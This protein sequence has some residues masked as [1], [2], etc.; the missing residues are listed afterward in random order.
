[1][2]ATLLLLTAVGSASLG[3]VVP[4]LWFSVF[5]GL[6]VFFALLRAHTPRATVAAL[7]G[8]LFGCATGG[9]GT[10][11]FWDTLPLSF[12]GISDPHV[13]RIA[14][15]MT[16]GFVAISLGLPVMIGAVAIWVLRASR[17]FPV[18]TPILWVLTEIGRMWSFAIT[19]WG[20]QSLFG[21][22]FSS[23]SIGY[24]IT[25]S[26]LLAR[27]AYPFGIDALNLFVALVAACVAVAPALGRQREVRVPFALTFGCA[28]LLFTASRS[29]ISAT[30]PADPNKL[31]VAII[32]ERIQDVR[33]L[34]THRLL[35]ETLAKVAAAKPPVDVIILPEE[36]S[37][38]SIFWSKSEASKFLTTHFGEREV[39]I[40]NTRNNVYP[41]DERNEEIEPKKLVYDTTSRG[42]V[43][44]YTKQMLM[45]LGEYAP[46]FT[47]TFFSLLDDPELHLYLQDVAAGPPHTDHLSVG[48]FHGVR[49]GGLLCSDMLS[50][51]L[52]R[53]LARDHQADVLVNLSNHFWFHGSRALYWKT[54][55]MARVHAIQNHAPLLVANNMAP[56]FALDSEGHRIA[57]ASWGSRDVLYVDL[58]SPR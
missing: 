39:L 12:L 19:T 52:Y 46:A 56:S 24:A 43:G 53:S 35:T 44:R 25:E 34:S 1:M 3:I 31:R 37:L 21:P 13:Q 20:T 10:I 28:L 36:F 47:Q 14:V 23:A 27:L 50:P 51:H 33:D 42:E 16:W 57:E 8:L 17:W 45:P 2:R 9:A 5:V 32:S 4:T 18:I 26:S 11:W 54:M 22:H 29:S 15:G 48:E 49:L 41:E 55:Q 7:Y 30:P 38:T 40:L 58:P 6:A